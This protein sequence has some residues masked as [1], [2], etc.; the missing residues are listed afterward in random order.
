MQQL[1]R[2]FSV[3]LQYSDKEL[4]NEI[5]SGTDKTVAQ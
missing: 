4:N 5:V 3:W 2:K 1:Q